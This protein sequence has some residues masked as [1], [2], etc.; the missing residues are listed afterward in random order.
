MI[1]VLK[2]TSHFNE[3]FKNSLDVKPD[4]QYQHLWVYG[5][6]VTLVFSPVA[7]EMRQISL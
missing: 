5:C 3:V 7:K 4:K 2:C 1:C 6:N